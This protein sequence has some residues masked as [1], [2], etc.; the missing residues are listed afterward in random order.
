M[1]RQSIA[2]VVVVALAA[3]A[4][5]ATGCS[6]TS[7]NTSNTN[8]ATNT[9]STRTTNTTTQTAT[10]SSTSPTGV[11]QASFN[12]VKNKDVAGFKKTLSSADLKEMEAIF[13][14]DGKTVDGF[15]KEMME[16]PSDMMPAT[17]ET[18]NEKIDGDKATLEYKQRDGSWKTTHLVKE[19]G[20]WKMKRVAADDEQ[21]GDGKD[22]AGANDNH[23]MEPK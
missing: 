8:T 19:D 3:I 12:A 6:K 18:R 10:P 1:K 14:K 17:L 20:E 4:V 9:S 2:L 22:S 16:L 23:N 21:S 7:T 11:M 15:L 5:A 13:A